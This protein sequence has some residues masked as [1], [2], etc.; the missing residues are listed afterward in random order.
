[1]LE[2]MMK[3]L[4]IIRNRKYVRENLVKSGKLS[5]RA[6][7]RNVGAIRAFNIAIIEIEAMLKRNG[8]KLKRRK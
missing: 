3:S 7:E 8:V 1:M 6:L 2:E 5:P 4:R